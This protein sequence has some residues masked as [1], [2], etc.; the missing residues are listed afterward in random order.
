LI[1]SWLSWKRYSDDRK[2]YDRMMMMNLKKNY[3]LGD[4]LLKARLD[5]FFDKGYVTQ[6]HGLLVT[7]LSVPAGLQASYYKHP[8]DIGPSRLLASL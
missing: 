7:G 5:D 3:T 6:P 2:D 4:A 1:E 8:T